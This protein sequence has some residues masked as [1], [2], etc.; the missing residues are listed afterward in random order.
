MERIMKA[1]YLLLGGLLVAACGWSR[2][3]VPPSFFCEEP[4][5]HPRIVQELTTWLSDNGDQVISVNLPDCQKSNRFYGDINIYTEPG[6]CPNV[7]CGEENNWF[8]Y[9]YIG[10]TESGVHILK[11]MEGGGTYVGQGFLLVRFEKDC[12]L[13]FNGTTLSFEPKSRLLLRR[14]GEAW[15]PFDRDKEFIVRAELSGSTLQVQT[16]ESFDPAYRGSYSIK[17]R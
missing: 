4:F 14:I 10:Q 15:G 6:V 11:I 9:Q 12:G 17:L 8:E 2:P 7:R 1:L 3:S 13:T 5:I 16:R